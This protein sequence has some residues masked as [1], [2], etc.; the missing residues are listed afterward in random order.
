MSDIILPC[1][2]PFFS[3]P[4]NS[5]TSEKKTPSTKTEV[6]GIHVEIRPRNKLLAVWCVV[7]R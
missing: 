7:C 4:Q 5:K 1:Y 2:P 6:V 3:L